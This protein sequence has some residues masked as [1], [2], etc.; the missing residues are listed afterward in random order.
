MEDRLAG[1]SG[2]V[3]P[4]LTDQRRL[5]GLGNLLADEICWRARIAPRWRCPV[6]QQT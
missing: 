6:C 3:K 1:A 5:A 2:M 4:G